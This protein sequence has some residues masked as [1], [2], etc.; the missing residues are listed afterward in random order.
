MKFIF[1]T[2][3]AYGHLNAMLGVAKKL[4]D[5]GHEV[6]VYNTEGFKEQIE[7]VGAK[8]H[9]LT[10]D[11]KLIDLRILHNALN[12]A[13][14]SLIL[15]RIL[16]APLV[17]SIHE[18]RP[19]CLIHDSLC[20]W[21]KLSGIITR[22][23]TVSLISNMTINANM[24]FAYAKYLLPDF[25][26]LAK[27]LLKTMSIVKQYRLLYKKFS[28][29]PPY[30]ID[31]FSNKE[32]SNIVFT[33]EYFQPKRTSFDASYKFVGPIIY[34]REENSIPPHLLNTEKPI[35]YIALGTVY[36]DNLTVYQN[37]IHMF[38]DKSYQGFVSIG[39]YINPDSLGTIP[40]NVYID[41]YLP[42]LEMLKRADLFI[43]HGGMNSVNE[44]LYFGVPML[45]IP[46]IQEQRVN[47]DRVEELGA[48]ICYP[49]K[50]VSGEEILKYIRKILEKPSYKTN[51]GIIGKTLIQA[52]GAEKAVEHIYEFLKYKT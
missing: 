35:I 16:T 5:D 20:I 31:L 33:S 24:M 46:H 12:I 11:Y 18:E 37:L 26:F 30:I 23:P 1:L 45:L 34:H 14:Q 9:K 8:F 41:K 19:D 38:K 51:A 27:H 42:Q 43:S 47:A 10:A 40:K 32:K 44:S 48:G 29:P 17:K 25:V 2:I 4:I 49:K 50:D 13:E 21:G 36:N 15:A 3:P 39:K 28:F 7:K 6:I 22:T 52:G